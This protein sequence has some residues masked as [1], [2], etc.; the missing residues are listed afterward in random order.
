MTTFAHT[1][2][3]LSETV[4]FLSP[5][6][7]GVY[8]DVTLGGGG[9][10]R[11]ILE[12]SE[13]DGRVIGVDRDPIALAA[14][15]EALSAFGD[16][17]QFVHGEFSSIENVV[18]EAGVTALDGLVADLGVSSPQFDEASR[19]FA[20]SKSGPLDMRMNQ[21]DGETAAELIARLD[22]EEL[23]NIIYR[24]GEE[25]KSRR[26][27]KE[28]KV[29][30][31]AGDLATTDDLKRAVTR[32]VGPKR[33]GSIDPAT[34]TFQAL[35]IAVNDELGELER[36]LAAL[37]NVLAP[38]GVAAIISFHSLE[39]RLVKY[40]FRDD[41]R[42]EPLTKKPVIASDEEL[43]RNPRARSAK[44]RGARFV[45]EAVE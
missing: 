29:S 17:V 14:S 21:S 45:P 13:P 15:R 31:D 5:R 33:F 35:R 6:A 7:G 23:A 40:A 30:S 19:G 42:F 44:L 20:F 1:T 12:A 9:H 11:A 8:A 2:V 32:A 26:I 16:R 18:R 4:A 41:P 25:R 28:L 27:A 22:E 38:N 10:T 39:D 3:L 36:L 34:K 37:P 43:E 24:Y